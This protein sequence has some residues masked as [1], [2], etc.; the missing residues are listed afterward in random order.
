MQVTIDVSHAEPVLDGEG[1][2]LDG[3]LMGC[4]LVSFGVHSHQARTPE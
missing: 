2:V 1:N 3:R 4:A